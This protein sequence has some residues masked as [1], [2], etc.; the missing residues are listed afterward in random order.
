MKELLTRDVFREAVFARDKHRCVVCSLKGQ[1]AH[2]II[3]RRL[4][5]DGGYYVDN[6]AT[7]CGVCHLRAESTELSANYIR[8]VAHIRDVVLPPHFYPD[9]EYDKWGN[10]VLPSGRRL[11]GE[12]FYDE[13]V[14]KV[15]AP[16]LSLFDTRVKYPRTMHLPW[17]SSI[18]FDDRVLSMK[19]VQQWSGDVVI[20]EKM[21]GENTTMYRDYIHARSVDYS[22][23]VSRNWVRNLHASIAHDIPD[24][25][26]ICGEN[27]WAKHS[28]FYDAL[29]SY[30]L[31]F[32]VWV[33][34]TCLS[35]KETVEW[36]QL[37]GLPT[38]PVLYHGSWEDFIRNGSTAAHWRMMGAM[39]ST[40]PGVIPGP[41]AEREVEGYVIR[42]AG[43]FNL[44]DFSS[45]VG[46]YV[47]PNHVQTHGHWM[48]SQFTPN[49]LRT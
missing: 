2:H 31:L 22:S 46:K 42:P 5:P 38:V 12:L 44:R 45:L 15:L 39:D 14:Q 7:L 32:S 1:D 8:A 21:D 17:S 9:E 37:L 10:V 30:F 16:A 28:I 19:R 11:I 23:H 18:T 24:N 47:R 3:E 43:S 36:A 34:T 35:W 4:F 33:R 27:L 49:K 25:Y 48:L 29:P 40:G 20:T 6:G 41:D 26:R 13:S